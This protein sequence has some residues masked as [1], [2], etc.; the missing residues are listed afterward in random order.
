MTKSLVVSSVYFPPQVGGISAMMAA[1]F[2][3]LGAA[4]A[5]CLTGAPAPAGIAD[6]GAGRVYRRPAAFRPP[7]SRKA[8]AWALALMEIMVRDRP[9]AAQIATI[10]DGHLGVWLRRWLHLPFLVYAHGNDILRVLEGTWPRERTQLQTADR[11]VAVSR[12]TAGLVEQ[13]GVDPGRI[14]VIHPGCD[15][16][17]FQ[18]LPADPAL[19]QQLLGARAP[20]PI[21]LTVGNLVERK[22]HDRVIQA[23]PRLLRRIPN[24]TYLV[25]G[26]G[27]YRDALDRLAREAGVRDHVVFAGRVDDAQL[28]RLYALSDVFVM[29]SRARPAECDVEGFGLVYLE[30]NACGKPVIGGRT[31]GI[32]EAIMDGKTGFLVDPEDPADIAARLEATLA[33]REGS[34]AMGRHGRA[35]V[36]ADFSWASAAAQVQE[37]ITGMV[38]QP[39]PGA[40][41]R[42]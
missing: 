7:R 11:V 42:D 23:L 17:H 39:N 12:F 13:A 2:A 4:R 10:D 27:P 19:R 29:A 21:L 24:A 6:K 34:A 22:G 14:R 38:A 33:D 40:G 28:P 25:V 37:L 31:G 9:R 15:A 32:P 18:P 26:D 3:H 20:G 16:G 35:R 36:K 41:A 8:A 30:A 1:L 5:C